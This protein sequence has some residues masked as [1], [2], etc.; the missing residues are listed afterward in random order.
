MTPDD[1][2][3]TFGHR[4][5]NR[6]EVGSSASAKVRGNDG[7]AVS[8]YRVFFVKFG[9]GIARMNSRASM[10]P[11]TY[12]WSL[13]IRML[14]GHIKDT[15]T[16]SSVSSTQNIEEKLDDLSP[17]EFCRIESVP[18]AVSKSISNVYDHS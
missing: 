17:A 15:T 16:S 7:W 5:E 9:I 3:P 1:P 8:G 12:G 4:I 14:A 10:W 6:P 18:P 11:D 2:L 13:E